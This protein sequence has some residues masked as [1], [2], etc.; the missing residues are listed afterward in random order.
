MT[1]FYDWMI[2]KGMNIFCW[3]FGFGYIESGFLKFLFQLVRPWVLSLTMHTKR[4]SIS[5]CIEVAIHNFNEFVG[6]M[7]LLSMHYLV[8]NI[9]RTKIN[10][11]IMVLLVP[12]I[13][14]Y[15]LCSPDIKFR[16]SGLE[17]TIPRTWPN[18]AIVGYIWLYGCM[19]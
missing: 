9:Y 7:V 19:K 8:T 4:W 5:E 6:L 17:G 18:H 10:F 13:I 11:E 3:Q 14:Q 12:R 2:W 16:N 15:N 1:R